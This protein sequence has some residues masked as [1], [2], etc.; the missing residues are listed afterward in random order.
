[1]A[2]FGDLDG[3]WTLELSTA[4][5]TLGAGSIALSGFITPPE[6]SSRIK[7]YLGL[8]VFLNTMTPAA[9]QVVLLHMLDAMDDTPTEV[10]DHSFYTRFASPDLKTGNSVKRIFVR[11]L[12]SSFVPF[13]IGVEMPAGATSLNA[14]GNTVHR[15]FY[16]VG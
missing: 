1:M 11:R 14:T 16:T 3:S 5:N 15:R 10:A 2:G 4:L 7:L 6:V 8:R 13:K 9:N 12:I